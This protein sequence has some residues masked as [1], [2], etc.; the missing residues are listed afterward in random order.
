MIKQVFGQSCIDLSSIRQKQLLVDQENQ[1]ERA[2]KGACAAWTL[3]SRQLPDGFAQ[4]DLP[5]MVDDL[6]AIFTGEDDSMV[7]ASPSAGEESIAG[8]PFWAD[9]LETVH[10]RLH[11]ELAAKISNERLDERLQQHLE[12]QMESLRPRTYGPRSLP[13]ARIDGLFREIYLTNS[14]RLHAELVPLGGDVAAALLALSEDDV[15]DVGTDL[16]DV[17]DGSADSLTRAILRSITQDNNPSR[18]RERLLRHKDRAR[19]ATATLHGF[20]DSSLELLH[21]RMMLDTAHTLATYSHSGRSREDASAEVDATIH[22]EAAEQWLAH[23]QVWFEHPK[24]VSEEAVAAAVKRATVPAINAGTPEF[25]DFEAVTDRV[26]R[27]L[28]PVDTKAEVIHDSEE[29]LACL[30]EALQQG[31]ET[32]LSEDAALYLFMLLTAGHGRETLDRAHALLARCASTHASKATEISSVASPAPSSSMCAEPSARDAAQEILARRLDDLHLELDAKWQRARAL[33]ETRLAVASRHKTLSRLLDGGRAQATLAFIDWAIGDMDS[34][35]QASCL[36][37]A[38]EAA[39][40]GVTHLNAALLPIKKKLVAV[41]GQPSASDGWDPLLANEYSVLLAEAAAQDFA[42]ATPQCP[43]LSACLLAL[44]KTL[45]SPLPEA[46]CH[47][48]VARVLEIAMQ[49]VRLSP[50]QQTQL[51]RDLSARQIDLPAADKCLQILQR[52]W[53]GRVQHLEQELQETEAQNRLALSAQQKSFIAKMCD[54]IASARVPREAARVANIEVFLALLDSRFAGS[55]ADPSG[56]RRQQIYTGIISDAEKLLKEKAT[57]VE[58]LNEVESVLRAALM[59]AG[60]SEAEGDPLTLFNSI[61]SQLASSPDGKSLSEESAQVIVKACDELSWRGV[62]P[63]Y[64]EGRDCAL[65]LLEARALQVAPQLNLDEDPAYASLHQC[66]KNKFSEQLAHN[67]ADMAR[68]R[69]GKQLAKAREA[70]TAAFSTCRQRLTDG[71][72]SE[73]EVEAIPGLEER[74]REFC[75]APKGTFV[76][77]QSDSEDAAT[78]G[79]GHAQA[80]APAASTVADFA[81][82]NGFDLWLSR[83]LERTDK[84]SSHIVEAEVLP[85]CSAYL[86]RSH[87]FLLPARQAS[88]ASVLLGDDHLP[89]DVDTARLEA[90]QTLLGRLSGT[91]GGVLPESVTALLK[92]LQQDAMTL[93]DHF[94]AREERVAGRRATW[95]RTIAGGSLQHLAD[96]HPIRAR[97]EEILAWSDDSDE[98]PRTLLRGLESRPEDA[99]LLRQ[100]LHLKSAMQMAMTLFGDIEFIRIAETIDGQMKVKGAVLSASSLAQLWFALSDSSDVATDLAAL[101]WLLPQN[102][103]SATRETQCLRTMEQALAEALDAEIEPPPSDLTREALD[104]WCADVVERLGA[105]YLAEVDAWKKRLTRLRQTPRLD[106]DQS[107]CI[108]GLV[109]RKA[110][111]FQATGEAFPKADFAAF[112]D[113]LVDPKV[114]ALIARDLSR[115]DSLLTHGLMN[116]SFSESRNVVTQAWIASRLESAVSQLAAPERS[117]LVALLMELVSSRQRSIMQKVVGALVDD[118]VCITPT[119]VD[120]VSNLV[121]GSFVLDDTSTRLLAGR[122]A[123]SMAWWSAI[124]QHTLE[125]RSKLREA[126]DLAAMMA[127]ESAGINASVKD[128]VEPEHDSGKSR[129]ESTLIAVKTAMSRPAGEHVHPIEK[130]SDADILA[131]ANQETTSG[132]TWCSTNRGAQLW[133]NPARLHTALAVFCRSIELVFEWRPRDTQLATILLLVRDGMR[134]D[135]LGKLAQVA[136]GEGKSIITAGV[137]IL[138]ALGGQQVDVVTSSRI[139]AE[140]DAVVNKPLFDMFGLS[141]ANN[142]DDLCEQGDGERP[143]EQIRKERYAREGRPTDI[144]Y[145]EAGAFERDQLLTRFHENEPD[146]QIIDRSRQNP[147]QRCALV[148]EV[149]SLLLDNASMTLYLSHEM[150]SLREFEQLFV[151]IWELV[152]SVDLPTSVADQDSLVAAIVGTLSERLDAGEIRLPG[153]SAPNAPYMEFKHMVTQRLECWVKSALLAR[154][155]SLKCEYVVVGDKTPQ[156]VVVDRGTG[157]EQA[158]LKWSQGLHQFLQ[159]KHNL[160]V[161]PESLK[162][163]FLS[164]L[165]FL[166]QYGK[167]IYGLSGTLGSADEENCLAKVFKVEAFKMPRAH[168]E[169]FVRK[170]PVVTSEV[171]AWAD[172]ILGEVR[173]QLQPGATAEPAYAPVKKEPRATLIVCDTI[174]DV[175]KLEKKLRPHFP[176]LHTYTSAQ[177][178]LAFLDHDHPREVRPG[179]LIIAT[180]LAGRGTDLK[181]SKELEQAGGLH[182]ILSYLP[183][184]IRIQEQAFGRTARGQNRGTGQFI[185]CDRSGQPLHELCRVRD[186]EERQRLD[187]VITRDVPRIECEQDLLMGFEHHTGPVGGFSTLL[188]RT[189]DQVR[190]GGQPDYYVAAQIQSLKNRWACWLDSVGDKLDLVHITHRDRIVESFRAMEQGVEADLLRD[191][192][193]LIVEPSVWMT[194]GGAYRRDEK[195]CKAEQCYAKAAEDP[196]YKV[197]LYYRA[198]CR[199]MYAPIHPHGEQKAFRADA[200]AAERVI[201]EKVRI[202]QANVQTIPNLADRNRQKGDADFGGRFQEKTEKRLQIWG[203]FDSAIRG[204]VGDT[205]TTADLEKSPHIASEGDAHQV[206][207]VLEEAGFCRPQRVA[208]HFSRDFALVEGKILHHGQDIAGMHRFGPVVGALAALLQDGRAISEQD[209]LGVCQGLTTRAHAQRA[210]ESKHLA[211]TQVCLHPLPTSWA[212]GKEPAFSEQLQKALAACYAKAGEQGSKEETLS[213]FEQRFVSS[214]GEEGEP[215]ASE[216]S[217]FLELL[218]RKSIIS[219]DLIFD[220]REAFGDGSHLYDDE[221]SAR[222]AVEHAFQ[223]FEPALV[224]ALCLALIKRRTTQM[225]PSKDGVPRA[226]RE[227]YRV[228]STLLLSELDIFAST[229]AAAKQLWG[230]LEGV[231]AIKAPKISLPPGGIESQTDALQEHLKASVSRWSPGKEETENKLPSG[232][233]IRACESDVLATLSRTQPSFSENQR[234]VEAR[235]VEARRIDKAVKSVFAII[236]PTIGTL[237]ALDDKK[238]TAK[239]ADIARAYFLD[240]AKAVPPAY[241]DFVEAGLEVVGSLIEKKDPP[242]WWE[243]TIVITMGMMQVVAGSLAKTLIPGAGELIGNVLISTGIDDIFFGVNSAITGEFSWGDYWSAKQSSLV[244]AVKS[245]AVVSVTSFAGTAL[246]NGLGKAWKLQQLSHAQKFQLVAKGSAEASLNL[247]HHVTKDVVR[248]LANFGIS[249]LASRGVEGVVQGISSLY[250]PDIEKSIRD[251]V[252]EK[253]HAVVTEAQALHDKLG[254]DSTVLDVIQNC[255]Q[256]VLR[257]ARQESSFTSIVRTSKPAISNAT[258]GVTNGTW[259]KVAAGAGDLLN[260]G[261][262]LPRMVNLVGDEVANLA[263]AIRKARDLRQVTGAQGQPP[264]KGALEE[265]LTGIKKQFTSEISSTLN[266][267]L[268][269]SVYGPLAAHGAQI[270]TDKLMEQLLPPTYIE[271][272]AASDKHVLAVLQHDAD[273]DA[274]WHDSLRDFFHGPTAEVNVEHLS[275]A[276]Q[277]ELGQQKV[278][279]TSQTLAEIQSQYQDRKLRVFRDSQNR[280]HVQRPGRQEYNQGVRSGA[281]ASEPEYLA[282]ARLEGKAISMTNTA[283]GVV[284]TY[285]P[286]GHIDSTLPE[287]AIRLDLSPGS[288]GK[289]AHITVTGVRESDSMSAGS[290]RDCFYTA[291]ISATAPDVST[292]AGEASIA[293]KREA[294]ANQ[295]DSD[296]TCTRFFK[297]WTSDGKVKEFSGS[298]FFPSHVERMRAEI[299]VCTENGYI[300]NPYWAPDEVRVEDR[301]DYHLRFYDLP[302][303]PSLFQI[304]DLLMV[305]PAVRA[306]RGLVST[307]VALRPAIGKILTNAATRSVQLGPPSLRTAVARRSGEAINEVLS[308]STRVG[309]MTKHNAIFERSGGFAQAERDFA[310]MARGWKV[311][312]D[313]STKWFRLPDGRT[314]NVRPIS[315]DGRPTLEVLTGKYS[316]KVRY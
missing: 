5:G 30:D 66:I 132:D 257:E 271:G 228:E 245:A 14:A 131:W 17:G 111:H 109:A 15:K 48:R 26:L 283:S 167:Q 1:A 174:D 25:R 222:A 118:G 208:K 187:R 300:S 7:Q 258:A 311:T 195:W 58:A 229:E 280:L 182:V 21:D 196:E 224:G 178:Q 147:A 38:I 76:L 309:K 266:G 65:S 161:S 130:W 237:R 200:K 250:A 72:L 45:E 172:A 238:V 19:D 33:A 259:G 91:E 149:D 82:E 169:K 86:K 148:D 156:V 92:T 171:A 236:E 315:T 186:H 207:K 28:L 218:R 127:E 142:C 120:A 68:E 223:G 6:H 47:A 303:E 175:H 307:G 290:S 281:L 128:W 41:M 104:K 75:A 310:R 240:N 314:I 264:G 219:D 29:L 279:G 44:I 252:D 243:V 146:Q 126:P 215:N 108:L 150:A 85:A 158:S 124:A 50:T 117:R 125:V 36:E 198:L 177:Q 136:T 199:L 286:D 62:L 96:N 20:F 248:S 95:T 16:L 296:Q 32:A 255:M 79:H 305:G 107:A 74:L 93:Q 269:S 123:G 46:G 116:S 101:D 289:P 55:H 141:V 189:A 253:W 51:Y 292:N 288:Q 129:L 293:A 144:I 90:V 155:L 137:A 89:S 114:L 192:E 188:Q 212:E 210:I 110:G 203:I 53:R 12:R 282:A 270:A 35:T 176:D 9:T 163:V 202:L 241:R 249:T 233:E 39:G 287:G 193:G 267:L 57:S 184:N 284:S 27:Y 77:C 217:A 22:D 13:L 88:E 37:Q 194:L 61:L 225:Q 105:S 214:G 151:R 59:R 134:E 18:L 78:V 220:L 261:V 140:R 34:P 190:G 205:I 181:T 54:I 211:A 122:E 295:L 216:R 278:H 71:P 119:T 43:R 121:D 49:E 204:A 60:D 273:P 157:V 285:H 52:S 246:K 209:L 247:A 64:S 226:P 80:S 102:W 69:A 170:A 73:A 265:S 67:D 10:V 298:R 268:S 291:L 40:A 173:H 297:K 242:E 113:E 180:N 4:K 84:L 24:W 235:L 183:R 234:L 244:S 302:V 230:I 138:K 70:R 206:L 260:L 275:A 191:W 313:G 160:P 197:A 23:V 232:E 185:I 251:E 263:R 135:K 56:V 97:L 112:T 2:V 254:G 308:T 294:I 145:G 316:K 231:R 87:S 227:H 299:G 179:D 239:F 31:D 201:R 262:M 3:Q 133:Q 168:G 106:P 276:E 221:Q 83:A 274:Y 42:E 162:A 143:A 165:F 312:S 98:R 166:K 11:R 152:S 63:Y 304:D 94:I 272:W 139:L 81:D 153:Y 115:P 277:A 100:I 99:D 103:A 213:A 301:H 256:E 154:S 159:L 164:N 8:L 306:A